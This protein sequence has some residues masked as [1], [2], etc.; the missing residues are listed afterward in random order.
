MA[1]MEDVLSFFKFV[2]ASFVV[3]IPA[4][5]GIFGNGG[6][7]KVREA[8]IANSWTDVQLEAHKLTE[9]VG[10]PNKDVFKL[11][12]A[13]SFQRLGKLEESI[14]SIES[15]QESS[16]YYTW[17]KV[18]LARLA[19]A[20]QNTVLLKE[21]LVALEKVHLKGD[22]NIEKKFFQAHVLMQEEKWAQA[23]KAFK[24]LEK[25]SK[26]TDLYMAVLEA[27]ALADANSS[28]ITFV[29]KTIIKVYT[30]FPMHDWFKQVGPEIKNIQLGDKRFM[31]AVTSKEFEARRKNLNQL[32][33]FKQAG[34]ELK[35]WFTLAAVP[36]KQQKIMSA[37][38]SMAE[39]RAEDS[40]KIL[41]EALDGERDVQVLS[42]LSFALAR[43]GDMKQAIDISMKVHQ[44]LGGSKQGIMA[45]YQAAAWS[46]Q[47]RDYESAETRFRQVPIHRISRAYQKEVQWYL[48]WLRYLKADYVTAEK[49]FRLMQQSKGKK[50]QK[51]SP[52][53]INYW[54][55]MALM[56]QGKTE[57][58]KVLFTKLFEKKG[59]NYYSF[60][61]RERLKQLPQKQN[62]LAKSDETVRLAVL[63]RSSYA[64]P[65]GEEAPWPT[66]DESEA[67]E[68]EI[69]SSENDES[70][71]MNEEAL[72]EANVDDDK[73]SEAENSATMELF[74][75]SEANLKLERAKAF[76]AVGLEDL[77]RN[78]VGD[79]ERYSRSFE[80]FK[81][82]SD[83]YR[84][85]GLYNK[86]SLLGQ[87]NS[88]KA[89]LK[90][91]RFVYEATFPRAYSEVVE[92]YATE[93]N[94]AQ[95]LVWGI[96]KA[97]S[98][99]RPWVKS[100]VGAMGLMQVMPSTGLKLAE[101]LN[102]K[103]FTPSNLLQPQ[104]AIRF[105]S[106]YL[107]RL[108]KKFDYS[109]QLVAAAYNAGPHRVSQ[110]LYYF[111]YMQMDEWVEHIPFLETR[112]YVKRV[113][114]N[115]MAY[116]ELYGKGL[117]DS[118]A[119]VDPVPVQIAG[120]PETKETW[121]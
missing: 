48:G 26:G 29:C 46:Y 35:K 3:V 41:N 121:E 28:K 78:E 73:N 20:S 77:A 31:C 70:E 19:Y 22:L 14:R 98:T 9:N 51:E 88:G 32:G 106:K 18:F 10:E 95:A 21:S 82:I 80:L 50:G 55:A 52:D 30:K 15:I 59:M 5:A 96:M 99:Y 97:E 4:W 69:S 57:K 34:D 92:K 47:T 61:A 62:D 23:S 7:D 40:V 91:N 58:A 53:R 72:A 90:A 71:L 33:E 103:N 110:W 60:L 64:T 54:L 1:F 89:N 87:A 102:V 63:G 111:G 105:G 2:L 94:V 86:L 93:H 101:M 67:T 113:T 108:C 112:N 36:L 75:Q 8:V 120:A 119:L 17:A 38:Q 84:Q 12:E 45:L 27:M 13:I 65:F 83:E 49:S 104:E 37:Q 74:S 44:L 39:G 11:V 6:K 43:S 79:L 56:K 66:H 118:L 114:V 107:E 76:W 115:Y 116:N 100:P 109:V 81:K 68:E 117:G 16:S 25:A 42:P 85:M 24:Q